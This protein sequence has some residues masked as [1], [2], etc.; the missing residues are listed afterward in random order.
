MAKHSGHP[1]SSLSNIMLYKVSILEE[2]GS[3]QAQ[4]SGRRGRGY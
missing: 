3:C 4:A 1:P 2:E